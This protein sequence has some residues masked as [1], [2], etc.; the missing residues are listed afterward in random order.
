[1]LEPTHPKQS[2]PGQRE[3]RYVQPETGFIARGSSLNSCLK[4]AYRHRV[5]MGLNIG[6]GW[7]AEVKDGICRQNPKIPCHESTKPPPSFGIADITR[8][9]LVMAEWVRNGA[10]WVSQEEADRRA[11]ICTGAADGLPCPKNQ[12]I[13]GCHGCKG[14]LAWLVQ[15][16]GRRSTK[17]DEKL[18]SCSVCKC[19]LRAKVHIPLGEA[20]VAGIDPAEFPVFCWQ[21]PSHEATTHPQ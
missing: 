20:S 7:D 10:P 16:L 4:A 19:F 1:M 18:Y 11:A 13:S 3:W 8:F 17:H 9:V 15:T 14:P 5:A 6:S 12:V 21:H 2:P